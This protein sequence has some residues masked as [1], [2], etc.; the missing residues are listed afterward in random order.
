MRPCIDDRGRPI[1]CDPEAGM[2]CPCC[3]FARCACHP[4]S[5][6]ETLGVPDEAPLPGHDPVAV[7]DNGG[8]GFE[9]RVYEGRD[10]FAPDAWRRLR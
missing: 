9:G 3:P 7:L 4:P 2:G 8:T 5:I 10:A 6:R 1:V